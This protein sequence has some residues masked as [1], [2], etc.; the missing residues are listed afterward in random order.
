MMRSFLPLMLSTSARI[1]S[2]VSNTVL[3]AAAAHERHMIGER[4]RRRQGALAMTNKHE[5]DSYAK[6]LRPILFNL[7]HGQRPRRRPLQAARLVPA[8]RGYSPNPR[9]AAGG[10]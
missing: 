8:N 7:H 4:T 6:A 9:L 5:A 2:V 3:A 1:F 10:Q